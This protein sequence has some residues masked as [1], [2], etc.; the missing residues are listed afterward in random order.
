MPQRY[1]D[2]I[3]LDLMQLTLSE[4]L[5]VKI[6]IMHGYTVNLYNKAGIINDGVDFI[7]KNSNVSLLEMFVVGLLTAGNN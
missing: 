7:I 4:G 5:C 6:K 2:R 3:S 1:N